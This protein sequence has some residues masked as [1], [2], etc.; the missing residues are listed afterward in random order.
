[1]NGETKGNK[2]RESKESFPF[3]WHTQ[4][5]R[6]SRFPSVSGT[7]QTRSI[8]AKLQFMPQMCFPYIL[9]MCAREQQALDYPRK[10]QCQPGTMLSLCAQH[11]AMERRLS[12]HRG[13]QRRENTAET[14]RNTTIPRS[15]LFPV[16]PPI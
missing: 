16:F 6:V 8:T 14:P 13:L 9:R 5:S 1:M 12:P 11:V 7:L 10:P 4:D 15:T 3:P 2:N